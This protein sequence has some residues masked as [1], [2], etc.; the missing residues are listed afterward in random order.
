M[1]DLHKSVEAAREA[2]RHAKRKMSD[3]S[4]TCYTGAPLAYLETAL[5]AL[6]EKPMTEDE[7]AEIIVARS[8]FGRSAALI[9]IRALRDA[10]VLYVAQI[11]GN[12]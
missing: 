2:I 5:S 6:P 7:I 9:L 10:G 4:G 1:T 8:W 12:G 3:G 11:E